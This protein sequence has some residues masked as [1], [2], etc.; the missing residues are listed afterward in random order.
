LIAFGDSPSQEDGD[1]RYNM[2][3]DSEEPFRNWDYLISRIE[4]QEDI[5]GGGEARNYKK[6]GAP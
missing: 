6:L 5:E 2:S 4:E 3:K 1:I